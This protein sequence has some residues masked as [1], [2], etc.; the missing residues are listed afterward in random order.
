MSGRNDGSLAPLAAALVLTLSLPLGA[1]MSSQL[2]ADRPLDSPT[3]GGALVTVEN[4]HVLDMRVY[5]IRGSTPIPLGS[6]STLE[7]RT[8]VVPSS[9]LGHSGTLR[10]MADPLGSTATFTSDW[11]PAAPGDWVEWKLEPN[12]RLSHFSVR[13]AMAGR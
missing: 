8:F 7:R 1:C 2:G 5:L 12:L 10:L 11:I 9:L 13:S 6:V 3:P 4:R